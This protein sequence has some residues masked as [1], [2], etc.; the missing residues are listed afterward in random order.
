MKTPVTKPLTLEVYGDSENKAPCITTRPAALPL[1]NL[2]QQTNNNYM[3]TQKQ[4]E[5]THT[6]WWTA[7]TSRNIVL[8]EELFWRVRSPIE[9]LSKSLENECNNFDEFD[10][11][12]LYGKLLTDF[13]SYLHRTILMTT[14]HKSIYIHTYTHT[15]T[16]TH[17]QSYN[18]RSLR[19][20]SHASTVSAKDR[21]NKIAN[22]S[23][24][25]RL[26]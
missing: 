2:P 26:R 17:T 20:K 3:V 22:E 21:I 18:N 13:S 14:L 11:G 10:I 9:Y 15:H 12:E 19:M 4:P 16:H 7:T 1:T 8:F 6:P 23:L 5:Q 25:F 24:K